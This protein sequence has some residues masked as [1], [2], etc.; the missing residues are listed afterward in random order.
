MRRIAEGARSTRE[1][2]GPSIACR[3]LSE[4][5]RGDNER[6]WYWSCSASRMF[7][8]LSTIAQA[9]W[10]SAIPRSRYPGPGALRKRASQG[11]GS[12]TRSATFRS[13]TTPA[14]PTRFL[15]SARTTSR[16]SH[17]V[18]CTCWVSLPRDVLGLSNQIIAGG[19]HPSSVETSGHVHSRIHEAGAVT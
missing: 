1:A 2:T 13:S 16:R 19:R 12:P 11:R 10:T 18:A 8:A 4:T 9:S 17:S 14:W 3:V 5:G 15:P 7:L 6:Q